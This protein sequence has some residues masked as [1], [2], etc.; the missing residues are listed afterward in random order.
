MNLQRI[1]KVRDI[2]K[3]ASLD[4]LLFLHPANMRY[5]SGFT[6]TDGAYLVTLE[7]TVFLTDSR[8]VEQARRQVFAD[9]IRLYTNKI[10]GICELLKP[11][12]ITAVGFEA[13]TLSYSSVANFRKEDEDISWIPLEEDLSP[14]RAVKDQGEISDIERATAI[15]E[16]SFET[17]LGYIKPG[18]TEADVAL[19]LEYLLRK[20]GGEEKAFDFIV[21]SG[22]R[23]ALPH[24]V[25]SSKVIALGEMVTV[26]FGTV[27]NGY[28]S[29]ET[30]TF[31]TGLVSDEL[32]RIF[33]IVYEA[34]QR[35]VEHLAPGVDLI[36]VDR[37]SRDYIASKG[38]KDY[39]GHGLGH[40]V[41]LEVHEYPALSP[42][43]KAV[44]Q[45]GMVLTIEPGIYLPGV[46][47]V[48]IEDM[49]V[50]TENGNRKLTRIP[51]EFR[52]I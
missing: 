4:A 42:R 50:I 26:D 47:G 19:E 18:M 33:D 30:V 45:E 24:G 51:K 31:A 29:D 11:L 8:Y 15:A 52:T 34:H 37:R 10:H 48:R 9:D 35:A 49:Y 1:H 36:E 27:V 39:F 46:G 44:G 7:S 17:L 38:Y 16:E 5:L 13:E 3:Q 14:L 21:A 43:S 20:N 6:G 12:K 2:M 25:A 23:G 32:K 28:H 40:A 22:H 41:G